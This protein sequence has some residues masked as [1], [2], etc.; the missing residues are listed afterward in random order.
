MK[1]RAIESAEAPA[2]SGGY[3]QAV[4]Y[5][6]AARTLQVSGQIPVDRDGRIPPDFAGQ[7]RLVWRNIDAQLKAAGMTLSDVVKVTTYLS[8]RAHADENGAIRR[9]VLGEIRPALTVVI[10]GIYDP[11]WL[12]EIEAIAA[13]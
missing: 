2:A 3:A 8:D 4:E 7:C 12:L 5:A 1:R 10:C 9:D 11:A 13:A 6:G